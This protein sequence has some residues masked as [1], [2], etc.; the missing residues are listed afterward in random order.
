MEDLEELESARRNK[1]Y[2]NTKTAM[3]DS[4][5]LWGADSE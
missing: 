1:K 5:E 4:D 3:A 2:M